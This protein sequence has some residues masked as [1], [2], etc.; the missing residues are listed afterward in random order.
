M[1]TLIVAL[2]GSLGSPRPSNTPLWPPPNTT[3]CDAWKPGGD[4]C[5]GDARPAHSVTI[6]QNFSSQELRVVEAE[7][8]AACSQ[9]RA[10]GCCWFASAAERVNCSNPRTPPPKGDT[11]GCWW[12][13]GGVR[14][15]APVKPGGENRPTSECSH[16]TTWQFAPRD[17][18]QTP[19]IFR[20]NTQHLVDPM[21]VFTQG[22]L[23]QLLIP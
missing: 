4:S 1:L 15:A 6:R 21:Q 9:Q 8:Q 22:S 7:C 3:S 18:L 19:L 5:V 17:A 10:N 13:P 11:C 16:G 2:S 14:K 12:V 20:P 23:L